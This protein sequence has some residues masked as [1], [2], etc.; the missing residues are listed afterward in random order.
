L[1][2]DLLTLYLS[3]GINIFGF[4]GIDDY[5]A[6]T[7]DTGLPDA[8]PLLFDDEFRAKPDYYAIIRVLYEHLP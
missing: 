7:N 6:W 5:N 8:N 3:K 4:G 1:F 2:R